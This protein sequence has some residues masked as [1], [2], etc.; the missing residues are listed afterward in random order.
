MYL[1][2]TSSKPILGGRTGT[3]SSNSIQKLWYGKI[4]FSYLLQG[5]TNRSRDSV[6]FTVPILWLTDSRHAPELIARS[7]I[8]WSKAHLSS[9]HS[10]QESGYKRQR[11]ADANCSARSISRPW[12]SDN[13]WISVIVMPVVLPGI[14]NLRVYLSSSSFSFLLLILEYALIFS[15]S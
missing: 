3:E 14:L 13:Q 10:V 15:S 11:A 12:V 5:I 9:I 4:L 1:Y 6:K 7:H 8:W 2:D